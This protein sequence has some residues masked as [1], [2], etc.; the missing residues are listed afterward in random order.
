MCS[1]HD[2]C[3]NSSWGWWWQ[4][5]KIHNILIKSRLFLV[6]WQF[7][8]SKNELQTF[9]KKRFLHPDGYLF[10]KY[11]SHTHPHPHPHSHTHTH[12]KS[13]KR[14]KLRSPSLPPSL[15]P[16][17]AGPLAAA[18]SC[19]QPRFFTKRRREEEKPSGRR[20]FMWVPP[21][22]AL[23]WDLRH[24]TGLFAGSVWVWTWVHL[25][26][27]CVERQHGRKSQL[28]TSESSHQT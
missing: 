18:S 22:F 7:Y 28:E 11:T 4:K 25:P 6:D 13:L 20:C 10:F 23:N 2:H 27:V 5:Y 17:W 1:Q 15:A 24:L 16:R 19:P 26:C 3:Y 9:K 14:K 12:P 21:Q 8:G